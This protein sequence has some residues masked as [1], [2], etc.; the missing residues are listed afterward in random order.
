MPASASLLCRLF[1]EYYKKSLQTYYIVIIVKIVEVIMNSEIIFYI[2]ESLD[3]GFEARALG[4]DIFTD[5]DTEDELKRNIKDAVHCHFN[6][7]EIPGVIKL[8]F[9]RDEALAL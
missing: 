2:E 9:V 4:F 5:G 1:F 7:K 6:E 8:H 3:G